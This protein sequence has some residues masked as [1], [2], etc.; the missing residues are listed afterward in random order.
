M[1][2]APADLVAS[3]T[4]DA[5]A[6]AFAVRDALYVGV[7]TAVMAS[8]ATLGDPRAWAMRERWLTDIGDLPAL[9]DGDNARAACR[10]IAGLDDGRSWE[11][12][13]SA[14]EAAPIAALAS[15]AGLSTGA[16][17]RWRDEYLAAAP[18]TVLATL[19]GMDDPRAWALREAAAPRCKEA[20]DSLV[21]RDDPRAWR[22]RA[23][24]ADL[25]P[26]AVV[27]SLGSLAE[28]ARG[29]RMVAGLLARHPSDISLLKN[30]AAAELMTLE[31]AETRAA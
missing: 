24:Y 11:I 9:V 16:A 17:W 14:R 30:A 18:K 4:G 29:S 7:P 20:L 25:W 15:L 12:R 28:T 19:R 5:G 26:G 6:A 27:K 1:S 2:I 10:S 31:F 23:A 21:G 13:A 22:L 8:L 3:T